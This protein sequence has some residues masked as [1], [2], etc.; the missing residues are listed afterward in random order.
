M[1]ENQLDNVVR[2][3]IKKLFFNV[4]ESLIQNNREKESLQ[5]MAVTKTVDPRLIN[6]AIESG[7]NL[8]GE[9]RVQEYLSKK[10]DYNLEKAKVHFIGNL[11]TNKVKYIIDKV[12]TIQ[13]VSSIKLAKEI[14]KHS[15][16]LGIKK[17]ILL[18]VNIGKEE[19]K[20]G[21][22]SDELPIALEEV[23]KMDNIYV[24]GLMCI[25]PKSNTEKFF[26]EMEKI[27]I[28]IQSKK[29]DNINMSVLSMG[30]SNDYKLAIKYNSSIIRIGTALFGNRNYAV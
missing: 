17:D 15:S 25:P 28:D 29:L 9:N 11:Q 20:T 22:F 1:M 5:I 7:I 21:F 19:N 8:L 18:E 27:F 4:N 26:Y 30:M 2:E 3:N 24:K 12:D 13:S 10:D 6:I 23:A 14:D 16:K